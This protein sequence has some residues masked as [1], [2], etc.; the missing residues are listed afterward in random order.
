MCGS[1]A[2]TGHWMTRHWLPV[3]QLKK[4]E[5]RVEHSHL[6]DREEIGASHDVVFGEGK[7]DVPGIIAELKRQGFKGYM[8]I[9]FE[10][11]QGDIPFLDAT[12]TKCV[13]GF[14]R[15]VAEQT[16]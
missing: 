13:A 5:G 12:L 1:C 14:D 6:K 2:D 7:S 11:K 8:S 4:L 16:K 10:Y 3:E 9:E 15:I